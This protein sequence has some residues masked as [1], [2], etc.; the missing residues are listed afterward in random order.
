MGR[1]HMPG[2][3]AISAVDACATL[4]L[5]AVVFG[6]LYRLL[7]KRRIRWLDALRGGLL[8][9]VVWEA[10]RQLL[11]AVLIGVRYTAAYG[12][13]GS[14]IALLL[15]CYWG[16][17]IIFFGAEYAQVLSDERHKLEA[18]DAGDAELPSQLPADAAPLSVVARATPAPLPSPIIP[19]RAA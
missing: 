7:P 3:V 2:A 10:G 1:L 17:S 4:V 15:W 8:A 14:F 11:G 18:P 16:V 5:N 9:A 19:R 12:A 13:I 6:L